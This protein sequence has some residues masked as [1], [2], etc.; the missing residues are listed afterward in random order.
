MS[1]K[2]KLFSLLLLPLAL[3]LNFIASKYP[4]LVETY[5]S[6]S[7]NKFTVQILSK[8]SGIFPFS[9]YEVTVYLI[10]VI[11]II[12]IVKLLTTLFKNT[13]KLKYFL[14]NSILNLFSTLSIAYFLFIILWGLNYNRLPLSTTLI[15]NYNLDKDKNIS[16][17]NYNNNDLIDLYKF[18]I[19]KTNE[20]RKLVLEDN[21]GIMK[22]NS[23]YKSLMSRAQL[24]YVK[25]TDIIPN[26]DGNYSKPKYVIS[27]N[28]MCYTGITGIYF[29]FTGDANVNI[30]VPDI[31]I[32]STTLHEM[33]HQ[34][35]YASEDEANFIGYLASINHPDIDFKYSGYML[36][37]N[38]TA[39]ALSKV[40]YNALVKL[41]K[42]ISDDVRRDLANNNNFW[43]KYEGKVEKVSNNFNNAYL[44]SN[45]I[46]EGVQSYG[47]MVE[48][49][50][51]Y[52]K[53]YPEY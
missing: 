3:L 14:I 33:A 46:K 45:G 18:L 35:G 13:T 50:L 37:L 4:E 1:K 29:P 7:I 17:V 47:K 8:I 23:D 38:H 49:L 12:F 30:A 43:K 26:A 32:P 2:Y 27:S 5:Y 34:R 41:N 51:T 44:K 20:T 9:T 16:Q 40:D 15:N 25:V 22:N 39:S 42:T 52:Y 28:L 6:L 36:A 21:N 31:Y 11:I 19:K 10:F 24:G 53:L 48:L